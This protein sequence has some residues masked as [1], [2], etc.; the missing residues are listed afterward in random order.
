MIEAYD[1]VFGFAQGNDLNFDFYRYVSKTFKLEIIVKII[2]KFEV[3]VFNIWF[4]LIFIID[5]AM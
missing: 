5:K 1:R 2:D 4:N 3:L